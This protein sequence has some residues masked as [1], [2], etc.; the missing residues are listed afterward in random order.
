MGIITTA[1]AIKTIENYQFTKKELEKVKK[2]AY[3]QG[4]YRYWLTRVWDEELPRIMW[5][6]LNPSIA[7]S[8][9]DDR[10]VKRCMGFAKGLGYG[11]I[12]IVNLFAYI[13]TNP[14]EIKYIIKH[15][16]GIE[17]NGEVS[18]IGLENDK[19]ITSAAERSDLIILG[20]GNNA[21]GY[22]RPKDVIQLLSDKELK[23]LEIN[24]S[25]EP[26]HPLFK[27]FVDIQDEYSLL[28]YIL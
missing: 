10:T 22:R 11:S 27:R 12:E 28:D 24:K 3:L 26:K 23:C 17:V 7:D 6:M 14:E 9:Q 18:V 4:K 21:S 15:N 16:K 13:A 19:Y 5:V 1:I 8:S 20:W 25:G 2:E